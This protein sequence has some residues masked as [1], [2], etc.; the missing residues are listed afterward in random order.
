VLFSTREDL[1]MLQVVDHYDGR[2]GM[3]AD[4]KSDKHGLGL[5]V[6]RKHKLAAQKIVVW[7]IELA[8][9]VLIWAR[10]WLRQEA[11]RL[12]TFGIVRLVA[13]VWAVP[14]RIT[15]HGEHL[16]RVCLRPEHPRA[17]DVWR[18]LVPL[19]AKGETV[20]LLG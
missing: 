7:L 2:A 4:L 14:G 9:N 16:L 1:A 19:L 3:E 11:P 15:L 8:H 18:G 13:E 20:L 10:E 12:S 6:L 17:R 5:A